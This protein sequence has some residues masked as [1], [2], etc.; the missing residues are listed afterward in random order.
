VL[1]KSLKYLRRR[2]RASSR[3]ALELVRFG[4]LGEAYGAPY[5]IIDEGEHH[6][7]RKYATTATDSAPAALLVPPL[8]VTSEVYDISP[9][10]SAVTALGARG[11]QPFVVDFGSPENEPGGLR[12][13][14]DDHVKAVVRSIERVRALTG[15]DV[16]V[17][18][19]SQGGMFA[20]QAAAY[21]RSAGIRSLVTFGSPVDIHRQL[22][23]VHSD[24]TGAL[25]RG[26]E[27]VANYVLER[28]EGLP[29]ALT[30]LGFKLLSPR[31]E[32][33]ARVEF[34]SKLHDRN[35][36]VRREARRRFLGGEGFVAWPGP[37]LRVF[38][39]EFIV[40]NRMLR[41]GFVIDGRTVSL[42][43]I[44]CP[45]LA[46]VGANDEMARPA[47][48]RAIVRAAPD[49]EVDFVTIPAGHFGLV[50][51]SRAIEQTWPAVAQ[52]IHF[53][54]GA[55]PLP[56][57]LRAPEPA[58]LLDDE[59]E[60]GELDI[61]IELL[62]DTIARAAKSGARRVG[63]ALASAN[64]VVA[65]IRYQEP[66]LRR[67]AGL[68]P[69]TRVS[70]A[71][72]L[73]E[74]AARAPDSTFFLYRDRAF[75]YRDAEARVTNV[76]RGLYACGVK[77]GDRVAVIMGSR[78]SFLSM[79]TALNRMR[80]VAVVVPPDAA[81]DAAKR[82]L[83]GLSIAHVV[84]DP[85]VAARFQPALGRDVLVLGGGGSA[86]KLPPGLVDMEAIDPA[87]VDL[88]AGFAEN[89]GR[90]RD[91]ALV[92]LRPSDDGA[93]RTVPV[94]NHRWTLS[95]L[96]AAAAC[97][98]TP[99][100]TVFGCVPL[101]H[102]TGILVSVGAA[103][104]AGSRLALVERFSPATFSAEVRRTGA[105]VV[106]YAGEMLRAL[107]FER[108]SPGDR[109]LPIRLFAGSGMRAD[110][111]ARLRERFG[112]SVMEF[113]AGTAQRAILANASGE[114][115]GALG[116]VLP[117]SAEVRV[118]RCDLATREL[119]RG[120]DDL[121]QRVEPGEAGVLLSRASDD[122]TE[123]RIEQGL[124]VPSDRWFVSNDVV[125]VDEDGDF[126]YVDSL[127]GFVNTSAGPVST[128]KI[129]DALYALP[130]VELAAVV[131]TDAG[132][133][134]AVRARETVDR[135]RIDEALARLSP[136]ERP[137]TVKQLDTIPLT[138]GFRPRK[139][140]VARLLARSVM[141]SDV[142]AIRVR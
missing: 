4:R 106:F 96:G 88:P 86:R 125:R 18:G 119:V 120:D 44:T 14:L 39:D 26:V 8:M 15:R 55:G 57:A 50:V 72:M 30:S 9:E 127:S 23:A 69:D 59:Y 58:P 92:L 122:D 99:H 51:G 90:A 6:R 126:W 62:F 116:R 128:R 104:A 20:Y 5:E 103:L 100:D 81:L 89:D 68:T 83:E 2:L 71:Q 113:Y 56:D 124:F 93:L 82:A 25:V 67:L 91:L 42:G 60:L 34:V 43:D 94:T 139:R 133:A 115:P 38:F 36:L 98:I 49:A 121:M 79:V 102:P 140:E 10:T 73:A 107:L 27:P 16:H 85:D 137:A 63:D 141:R 142:D 117:G 45:V 66:R 41:G 84:A 114:K 131:S 111:V 87:R 21:L 3:N 35:A 46:F 65:A 123:G 138:D 11:V 74:Q 112:A 17:L 76:V 32:L 31:K 109:N 7:L 70:P 33:Q 75:S 132:L 22:P 1:E 40:H 136:H 12:R 37:A 48:V 80:A 13:T 24:V 129:E 29:G 77:P 134:T 47:A 105:S 54:E 61:E 97:T 101:H 95:A 110:L 64:D 52:W 118:V 53:R 108:P 130:E 19:Y 135:A 78:P 28:I